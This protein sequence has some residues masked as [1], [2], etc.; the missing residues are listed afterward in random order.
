MSD[1]R[2]EYVSIEFDKLVR[3]SKPGSH[4]Q[5]AFLI[6]VDGDEFWVAKSQ[7]DN[8]DELMDDLELPEHRREADSIEV[9]KWLAV[10]N[11]WLDED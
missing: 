5:G 10:E 3:Q 7:V 9:P 6:E 1:D 2:N 11:G 8:V 4:N